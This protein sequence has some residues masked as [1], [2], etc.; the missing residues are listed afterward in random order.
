[1]LA[2]APSAHTL[3]LAIT[4]SSICSEMAN[5]R[6]RASDSCS[7]WTPLP[8]TSIIFSSCT[9]AALKPFSR[10]IF[11]PFLGQVQQCLL[12]GSLLRSVAY[13]RSRNEW[14]RDLSS[15]RRAMVQLRQ[16][17]LARPGLPRIVDSTFPI[18]ERPCEAPAMFPTKWPCMT[19][20]VA[21]GKG[22]AK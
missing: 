6:F 17:R 21:V 16:H 20:I 2:G 19:F 1:M 8:T 5:R 14:E 15:N 4:S 13:Q 3:L 11:L 22:N 10:E 12:L 9:H 18:S 7:I